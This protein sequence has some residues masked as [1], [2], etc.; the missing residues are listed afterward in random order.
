VNDPVKAFEHALL[1]DRVVRRYAA[2]WATEF[3]SEE[4]LKKYLR[5]HPDADKSK[6]T[7]KK[8]T[9]YEKA[10]KYI[11]EHGDRI[12]QQLREKTQVP[13]MATA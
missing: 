3:P 5:E 1:V 13:A 4:A 10:K 12:V 11:K 2:R 9:D 8:V 6:H 7:V